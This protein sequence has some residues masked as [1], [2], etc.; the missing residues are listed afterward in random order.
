MY[1]DL[2][3]DLIILGLVGMID[4]VR[5]E[6]KDVIIEI[7]NVGIIIIMIIGDYK[8]IV[9]VIVIDLGILE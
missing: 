1:D 5:F 2:E 6:V 3:N 7:K 4:L 8:N 9:V